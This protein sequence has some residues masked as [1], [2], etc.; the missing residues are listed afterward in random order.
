VI[1]LFKNNQ[2]FCR[3]VRVTL[4]TKPTYSHGGLKVKVEYGQLAP[5]KALSYFHTQYL[6]SLLL[7]TEG[8]CPPLGM[9]IDPKYWMKCLL[10]ISSNT[11]CVENGTPK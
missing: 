5:N 8:E 1:S 6:F 3:K 2:T 7:S 10:G 9:I 11:W 4:I